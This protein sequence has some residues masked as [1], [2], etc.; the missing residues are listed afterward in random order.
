MMTVSTMKK[1]SK[2]K[3]PGSEPDTTIHIAGKRI[4]VRMRPE[5]YV[6]K[7]S[8]RQQAVIDQL[9]A[10]HELK[11]F[12]VMVTCSRMGQSVRVGN[13][14]VSMSTLLSLIGRKLVRY[15]ETNAKLHRIYVLN[16]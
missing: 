10:G 11:V 9:K 2:L 7:L 13:L 12:D 16:N 3:V 14:K 1:S 8:K 4:K 5:L 15:K 6:P